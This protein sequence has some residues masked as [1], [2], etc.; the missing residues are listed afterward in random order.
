MAEKKSIN[1]KGLIKSFVPYFKNYKRTFFVDLFCAALTTI[2]EIVL[3]MI[4]RRITDT[5]IDTP[6]N[7]TY[8]LIIGTGVFYLILR[9]IDAVANYYMATVGHI[10]GAK[11]ETDMRRDLFDHMQGLSYTYYDNTKVGQL[12][13]RITSDLFDITEFAHHCP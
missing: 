11:I 10:M 7:L 8:R 13:S 3:P 5:A 2:C 4:V 9:G 6:E 12:M 1:K